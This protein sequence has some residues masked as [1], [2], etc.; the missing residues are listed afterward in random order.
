MRMTNQKIDVATGMSARSRKWKNRKMLWSD[1]VIRLTKEHK[2]NETFKEFISATKAEQHKIK[3]VGGYVGGY[4]RGGKRSPRNVLHRQVLTLDIDF[5]R[6]GFWEDFILQYDNAAVLHGTHKH[7]T[8]NPRLRL[9]MPL[10]RECSPDEYVAVARRIAGDL[11]VELFDNTTF[12][13]NRLMFW[14][15]NPIDVE[16][17]SETQEGEWVDVDEVLASYV[18]WK[19]TSAWPTA[20]T[21]LREVLD[22]A[23]KQEDPDQK[24]GI[25]GAF[26]RAYN[27]HEVI[28]KYLSDEYIATENGRYTY[29]KGSTASGLITY[30]DKFAFS[31]HGTDPTSGMLCNAF[32][33]VRVHKFGHLGESATSQA[34]SKEMYELAAN[35]E[36][37]RGVLARENFE[38]SK[39]DF[40]EDEG[41]NEEPEYTDWAKA[42][43]VDKRGVN[44]S[45]AKNIEIILRN[46]P[47][48]KGRFKY[49]R[50]DNKAYMLK[51]PPWRK[52]EKKEAIRNVDFAGIRN[53]FEIVYSIASKTKIEDCL[54]LELERQAFHPVKEFLSGLKWDKI[55]RVDSML[56]DYFRTPND[57]YHNEAIRKTLCGAVARIFEPGVKFDMVLVLVG[58]QGT[59]KSTIARKL[60]KDWASD[61]FSTV[62]GNSA[63][64]QLQGKWIIEMGELA[65]LRKADVE[66]TKHFISKQDD[67]FRPAYGRTVETY[68]RQCIFIGTTNNKNFLRDPSGNRRFIPVSI[69]PEKAEK[70]IFK[71]S[72]K[73]VDQIWAEA[74]VMYEN[75]EKLYMS[76]EAEQLAKGEQTKHSEVDERTGMVEAYLAILLPI[77][78]AKMDI[79]ARRDYLNNGDQSDGEK[80]EHVCAAEVW[81]ECL[82]KDKNDM[83]RYK[84]REINDILRGLDEWGQ[85]GSTKNFSLYGKQK[86]Y[87]RK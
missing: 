61:T 59:G 49:N 73:E 86:Y 71:I 53:Y 8:E 64:E 58:A 11:D 20:E 26:C 87:F 5:A 23:K 44:L 36:N 54:D 31:H 76:K 14:P 79:F 82:S 18:D 62:A 67:S 47:K 15:S 24:K 52:I 57:L 69:A 4:L 17:Y 43:E 22:L 32:D 6:D 56:T 42:L 7:S 66:T 16:Y 35:D 68:P 2:T 13:T 70:S 40:A 33:L 3:D 12:E 27:I 1:L 74:V 29:S 25:V 65:G 60:G 10:S 9:V 50:F 84:T 85:N 21:H 80:R 77:G 81:A 41:E 83:D 55:K 48:I 39:Y 37:A 75:G 28:E 30:E 78:W 45:S 38:Q 34:S 72:E 46:D 19:D 63:F 51:S